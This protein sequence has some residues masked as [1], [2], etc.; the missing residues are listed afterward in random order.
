MSAEHGPTE[1]PQS[2]SDTQAIASGAIQGMQDGVFNSDVA[3][4][5]LEFPE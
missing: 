2:D 4:K 5:A 1:Q 3:N